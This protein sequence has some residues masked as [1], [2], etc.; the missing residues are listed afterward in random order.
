MR[1]LQAEKHRK[2]RSRRKQP[3]KK[4]GLRQM[5]HSPP[6]T[7]QEKQLPA[8]DWKADLRAALVACQ[9]ESVFSRVLCNEK[10]RWKYCPGHWGSIDECPKSEPNKAN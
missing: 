2:Q 8:V 5:S 10:A 4:P 3:P 9:S 7:K 6:P 1:V